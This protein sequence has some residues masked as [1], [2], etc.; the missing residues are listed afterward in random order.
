MKNYT[1]KTIF[2]AFSILLTNNTFCIDIVPLQKDNPE[3]IAQVQQILETDLP[4]GYV[5]HQD[6]NDGL[7]VAMKYLISPKLMTLVAKDSNNNIVGV[8]NYYL[9]TTILM[10]IW[11]WIAFKLFSLNKVRFINMIIV[12]QDYRGKGIGKALL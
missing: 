3:E 11:E 9:K 1:I 10:T 12:H 2:I 4:I 5:I 6:E 8:I 7:E